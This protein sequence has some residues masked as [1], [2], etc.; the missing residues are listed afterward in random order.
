MARGRTKK[1]FR[2]AKDGRFVSRRY[3]E[4]HASTTVT[5]HVRRGRRPS[6][7]L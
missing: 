3:V 5:E 6:R 7:T 2:S 4:K 1:V